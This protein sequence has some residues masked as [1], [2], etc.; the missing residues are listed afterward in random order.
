M[1]LRSLTRRGVCFLSLE[2][3]CFNA[4]FLNF[5]MNDLNPREPIIPFW[6]LG[7]L[8]RGGYV[9]WEGGEGAELLGM[10]A[11]DAMRLLG[12][13]DAVDE[14]WNGITLGQI[15]CTAF[16]PRRIWFEPVPGR[17]MHTY[18]VH[19][20]FENQDRDRGQGRWGVYHGFPCEIRFRTIGVKEEDMPSRVLLRVHAACA[21]TAKASGADYVRISDLRSGP[22]MRMC[23]RR[24]MRLLRGDWGVLRRGGWEVAWRE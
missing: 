5:L 15:L 17:D 2:P 16:G 7:G 23:L 9:R 10:F 1:G 20:Q 12:E 21:R 24:W 3:M 8:F 6:M 18:V 13:G 22:L 19:S 11:P 14:L 4:S